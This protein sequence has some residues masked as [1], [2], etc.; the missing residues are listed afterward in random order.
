MKNNQEFNLEIV[1][2]N[3]KENS[4]S[5]LLEEI[6]YILNELLIKV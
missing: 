4:S 2:E 1:L 5:I 6:L 3:L